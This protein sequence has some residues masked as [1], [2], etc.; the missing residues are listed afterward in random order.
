MESFVRIPVGLA[1]LIAI[2]CHAHAL[3]HNRIPQ[4]H[5]VRHKH[6]IVNFDDRHVNEIREA[7]D[8]YKITLQKPKNSK[9]SFNDDID[10]EPL[11]PHQMETENLSDDLTQFAIDDRVSDDKTM[12]ADSRVQNSFTMTRY[13]RVYS[14]DPTTQRTIASDNYDEEYDDDVIEKT[15]R[16]ENE[17]S[18]ATSTLTNQDLLL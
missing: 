10:V 3:I 15:S 12:N 1:F 14:T 17:V 8:E 18:C 11:R 9:V 4:H 5:K 7:L 6:N 2:I 16:K 13:K